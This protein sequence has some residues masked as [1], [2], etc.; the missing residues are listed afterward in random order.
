MSVDVSDE[1]V[2]GF[3]RETAL[4]TTLGRKPLGTAGFALFVPKPLMK[5]LNA[6]DPMAW[7]RLPLALPV[8][9][10]LRGSVDKVENTF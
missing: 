9:G 8:G 6:K 4:P 1:V 3:L 2:I 10:D 7:L 5:R